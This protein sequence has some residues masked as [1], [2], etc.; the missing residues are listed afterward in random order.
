M[1]AR[2]W[3]K[4]G[5]LKPETRNLD[6][7]LQRAIIKFLRENE[8]YDIRDLELMVMHTVLYACTLE[9]LDRNYRN[10]VKRKKK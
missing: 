5:H 10:S 2:A 9:N 6:K 4:K 8:K 3:N 1:T 7:K